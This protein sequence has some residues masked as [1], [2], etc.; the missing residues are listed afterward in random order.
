MNIGPEEGAMHA[1]SIDDWQHEHVFLGA[2]HD[3]NERRSWAVVMLCL[4]MMTAEIAGGLLWGSM[5]LI[6]DGLHMSTHAG[7]YCTALRTGNG[8][9]TQ[10]R[11]W[12]RSAR[13]G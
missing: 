1:Q 12:P 9:P 6:A 8:L 10:R 5:A 4:T 3:R 11:G 2:E 7:R 13:C